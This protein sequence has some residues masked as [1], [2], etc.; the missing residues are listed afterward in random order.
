MKNRKGFLLA[1]ET[2]KIVIAVICIGFLIYLLVSLYLRGQDSKNLELA[3]ASL[4]HLVNEVTAGVTEVEIYNPKGWIIVNWPHNVLKGTIGFRKEVE[5]SP[6]FCKNLGWENCL[7]ICEGTLILN[8]EGSDC[9][10]LGRCIESNLVVDEEENQIKIDPPLKL[11]INKSII[12]K[13]AA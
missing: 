6:N 2:L 11:N 13:N 12:T 7:C 3:E 5:D 4:E 8:L 9:D 10:N 1:E